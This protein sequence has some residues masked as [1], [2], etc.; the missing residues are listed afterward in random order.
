MATGV[1]CV[2]WRYLTKGAPNYVQCVQSGR[3]K[4]HIEVVNAVSGGNRFGGQKNKV[5]CSRLLKSFA[6]LLWIHSSATAMAHTTDQAQSA[7]AYLPPQLA[8]VLG[9]HAAS[10][11]ELCFM[12]P[13]TPWTT[14]LLDD[15][16]ADLRSSR[17]SALLAE[18][19]ANGICVR[20]DIQLYSYSA[21]RKQPTKYELVAHVYAKR[22]TDEIPL[23]QWRFFSSSSQPVDRAGLRKQI[24]WCQQTASTIFRRGFCDRCYDKTPPAKRLKVTGTQECHYCLLSRC[25]QYA[26]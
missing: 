8:T 3:A 25:L 16:L 13:G 9:H 4:A 1:R 26:V 20:A 22:G 23:D 2:M 24:E 6:T 17:N 5:T 10:V 15:L 19:V 21:G 7:A 18:C 14:Q 12:A 11:A